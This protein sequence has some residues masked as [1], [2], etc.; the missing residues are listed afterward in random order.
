MNHETLFRDLQIETSRASGETFPASL[1]SEEPYLRDFG[2]EILS[3][4]PEAIEMDRA[5]HGLPLLEGHKTDRL[6]IGRASNVRAEGG[7]LRAN[8]LLGK[9]SRAKEIR[10]DIL[11]G[12]L[13][14]LSLGYEILE[15]K[16]QEEVR[17]GH[18]VYLITRWRPLEVSLVA[19]PAD[20]TVGIGRSRNFQKEEIRMKEN[21][22]TPNGDNNAT[23]KERERITDLREYAK[24][25][26][27]MPV[28]FVDNAIENGGDVHGLA[29]VYMGWKRSQ[30]DTNTTQHFPS[31]QR[32]ASTLGLSPKDTE[33]FSIVRAVN[34][35]A[36]NDWREA[37]H[38]KE[39][40][41]SLAKRRNGDMSNIHIPL[42][43]LGNQ[44]REILKSGSGANLIPS[45]YMGSSFIDILRNRARVVE[46]GATVLNGLQGDVEIPRK[47]ATSTA[48]WVGEG[49]DITESTPTFDQLTLTPKTLGALTSWSRKL[50]LQG[51]PDI[52]MLMRNDLATKLAV[53]LDRVAIEG[54]GSGAEP[55]GILNTT[56][57]GAIALGTNG[58]YPAYADLVNLV[59]EV[60]ADNADI[61]KLGFMLSAT[62]KAKLQL[63]EKAT[64]TGLF[65]F[66]DGENGDGRIA[67]YRA[68]VS[69]QVPDDLDKGTSEGICSAVIFGDFSS[70]IIG[71]W[72]SLEL[73]LDNTTNFA[74]AGLRLR[75]ILDADI[76]IRH[77]PS[78]AAIQDMLTA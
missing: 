33:R 75:A 15:A 68:L 77:A 8:L 64:D 45:D 25:Q 35:L 16:Q 76:G 32:S 30:Q 73:A 10:E 21:I 37:G 22:I 56:G 29:K 48:Y 12:V 40:S 69:N 4:A 74:S 20:V 3:H 38:E 43:V 62:A 78:F 57:I 14:P 5:V 70:C 42:E 36:T 58:D 19:L 71:N 2:W 53:E 7:K 17:D 31:G 67:G 41:D 66:E 51:S 1:S 34:A 44:Q 6:N 65:V 39:V 60:A 52:E 72:G 55:E 47:T 49:S 61:G 46:A 23:N 18:A 63:T 9:T 50:T 54:S 26:G 11:G 28:D 59:K 13:G 27:D 24:I